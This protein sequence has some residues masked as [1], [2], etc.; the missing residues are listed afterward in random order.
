MQLKSLLDFLAISPEPKSPV[1]L[2]GTCK[3]QF[4]FYNAATQPGSPRTTC[5]SNLRVPCILKSPVALAR[6]V[7][8]VTASPKSPITSAICMFFTSETAPYRKYFQ[9]RPISRI[10]FKKNPMLKNLPHNV[11]PSIFKTDYHG[12]AKGVRIVTYSMMTKDLIQWFYY[13]FS[14]LFH[15][16]YFLFF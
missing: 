9:K 7:P 12:E 15:C 13:Q 6:P 5:Q 3:L 11:I 2:A 8:R 14:C 10:C 4:F 1:K 16:F